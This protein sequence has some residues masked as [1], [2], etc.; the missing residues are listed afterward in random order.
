VCVCVCVYVLGERE[1]ER[2]SIQPVRRRSLRKTTSYLIG[3]FGKGKGTNN[4]N[5]AFIS[6]PPLLVENHLADGLVANG[7]V[8][9]GLVADG[10]VA[11]GLVADGLVAD[12]LVADELVADGLVA[13]GLMADTEFSRRQIVDLVICLT[14]DRPTGRS[15]QRRGCRSNVFRSNALRRNDSEPLFPQPTFSVSGSFQKRVLSPFFT[16]FSSILR[17]LNYKTF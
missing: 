5:S 15:L 9:D 4:Q 8:A 3:G 13:D 16:S 7:L 12:G 10:L 14:F 1:R 11:D 6:A 17:G 2:C